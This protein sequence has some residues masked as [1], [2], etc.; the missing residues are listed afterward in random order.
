MNEPAPMPQPGPA[1]PE[2]DDQD[3]QYLDEEPEIQNDDVPHRHPATPPPRRKRP[4][5]PQPMRRF[6]DD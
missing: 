1:D 4:R 3:P 2:L 5:M 6:E